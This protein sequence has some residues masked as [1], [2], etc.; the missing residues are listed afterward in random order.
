MNIRRAQLLVGKISN[1]VRGLVT[2]LGMNGSQTLKDKV[3]SSLT[4]HKIPGIPVEMPMVIH[5]S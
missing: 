2:L 3:I 4:L 5:C 1:T